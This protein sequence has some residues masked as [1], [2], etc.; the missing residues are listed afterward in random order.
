MKLVLDEIRKREKGLKIINNKI[1]TEGIDSL[2]DLT[3]LAG[4]FD[5]TPED[6]SLLETYAGPAV[7]DDQIQK[8][9]IE[10]LGGEKVLPLNR[11]TSGIAAL[12]ITYVKPGTDIVHFLA[13]QPGHPSIPRTAKL[14][15]ANYIE[16][17]DKDDFIITDN[18]SLVVITGTTM[19]YEAISVDDFKFVINKAKEKDI[20]VF[21]DD[22]SGARLRRA[23]YNQPRAIDLGADLSVTSTDKL[24]E[25]PR[26]GLMAGSA[27]LID[28]IKLTVN[29]YGWEAQAPLVVG[30]IK[31]LEKYSP[32]RIKEAYSQKDELI[33]KLNDNDFMPLDTPTGFMFKEEQI[34]QVVDE[35][36][37]NEF[38]SDIIATVYSMLLLENY[39][40]ITIPSVGMPGAS[41]TVRIDWSSRDSDKLSMDD[42]VDAIIDTFEKTVDVIKENKVEQLLYY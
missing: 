7:F 25:G 1:Q 11:T 42:M 33:S 6:V 30:M 17:T 28:E 4:G 18:T 39:N 19:D 41:K 29:Q 35:K 20:L 2:I 15:G 10:H 13:E 36:V 38:S 3:G 23:V 5:I 32:D 37:S 24:M 21:V 31:G 12:I 34:K 40:I 14:V 26:G 9:G 8:L 22:A 16:Y 27:K